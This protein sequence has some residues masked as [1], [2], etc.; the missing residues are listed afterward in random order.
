M[1]S[2]YN[3]YQKIKNISFKILFYSDE[4]ELLTFY[5]TKHLYRK[6]I[7]TIIIKNI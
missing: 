2:D 5:N 4:Y 6:F 3:Y 7:N 1:E